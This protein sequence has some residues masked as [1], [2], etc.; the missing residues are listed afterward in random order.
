MTKQPPVLDA[1]IRQHRLNRAKRVRRF[2]RFRLRTLFLLTTVVAVFFTIVHFWG[3][4]ALNRVEHNLQQTLMS[5]PVTP[6][7]DVV[8]LPL[9]VCGVLLG[10]PVFWLVRS[11][12]ETKG[13]FLFSVLSCLC[14]LAL[15]VAFSINTES[16]DSTELQH[17]KFD[18]I[19]RLVL[20]MI[21][22]VVPLS[23]ILGWYSV[24]LD[25]RQP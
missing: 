16:L 4:A 25:N 21:A 22:C 9:I 2:L 12:G 23:A 6:A 13:Y 1:L 18:Q 11:L 17:L 24:C 7:T 10:V 19:L 5:L 8:V 3:P 20:F 15:V 14:L